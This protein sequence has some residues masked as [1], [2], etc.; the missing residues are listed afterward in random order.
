MDVR[1]TVCRRGFRGAPEGGA[2]RC[3]RCRGRSS[4]PSPGCSGFPEEGDPPVTTGRKKPTWFCPGGLVADDD[5]VAV[6][7]VAEAVHAIAPR[8]PADGRGAVGAAVAGLLQRPVDER[9]APGRLRRRARSG[10]VCVVRTRCARCGGCPRPRAG[11]S[12]RGRWP[13]SRL[14]RCPAGGRAMRGRAAFGGG[15]LRAAWPRPGRFRR[16]PAMIRSG[17]RIC[18]FASS[19][20]CTV[21]PCSRARPDSVLAT[22]DAHRRRRG[23][24][25]RSQERGGGRT[26][27]ADRGHGGTPGRSPHL[28]GHEPPRRSVADPG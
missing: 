11:R 27:A 13:S 23:V 28:R 10:C 4:T 24:G 2:A 6:V 1:G 9:G 12:R 21:V 7:G 19:S 18:G 3:H 17:L 26:G 16:S 25:R 5:H 14:H 20:A 22:V 8:R 15:T